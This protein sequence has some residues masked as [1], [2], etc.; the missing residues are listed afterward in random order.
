MSTKSV[1]Q[2]IERRI[3]ELEREAIFLRQ[4]LQTA[5]DVLM[6]EAK[7]AEQFLHDAYRR[8]MDFSHPTPGPYSDPSLAPSD[9]AKTLE[10]ESDPSF[11]PKHT[12]QNDDQG[13]ND[14][15]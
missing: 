7:H 11:A 8:A 14:H 3:T 5:G 12:E 4:H 2:V 9:F 10:D 15:G 13:A 6:G 1:Y